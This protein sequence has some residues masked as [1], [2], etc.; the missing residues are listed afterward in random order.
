MVRCECPEIVK[1]NVRPGNYW[2][3][4]LM[5]GEREA[6]DPKPGAPKIVTDFRGRRGEGQCLHIAIKP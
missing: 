6:R 5:A 2:H 1:I 3:W 4:V